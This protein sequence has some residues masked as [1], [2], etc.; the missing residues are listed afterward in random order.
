MYD[1]LCALRLVGKTMRS[2]VLSLLRAHTI[3]Q[4]YLQKRIHYFE[5]VN[6]RNMQVYISALCNNSVQLFALNMVWT[7]LDFFNNRA[8]SILREK[9]FI[10]YPTRTKTR[11]QTNAKSND[12][13][14]K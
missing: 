10:R 13:C 9:D 14:S 8:A 3:R 4:Q 2:S 12:S 1:V 6:R 5:D 7:A 11:D